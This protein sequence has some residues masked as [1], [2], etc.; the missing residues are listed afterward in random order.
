MSNQNENKKLSKKQ[1]AIIHHFMT[2]VHNNI[3]P[4]ELLKIYTELDLDGCYRLFVPKDDIFNI[5]ETL[6]NMFNELEQRDFKVIP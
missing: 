4:S 1:I 3:E 5:M 6:V 2:E